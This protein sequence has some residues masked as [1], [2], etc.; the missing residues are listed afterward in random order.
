[1]NILII[2]G[3]SDFL[4]CK[5]KFGDTHAYGLAGNYQEAKAGMDS[6]ELVFDFTIEKDHSRL[7][8]YSKNPTC[9]FFLNTAKT[10]LKTLT[11]KNDALQRTFGFAG[12]P[13]FLNRHVL[14]VSLLQEDQRE[15]LAKVCR[16]LN[17]S[18]QV[19][20]DRV[21]LVTPR[22]ICMII[23]E[24]YYTVEE[25]TATREDI[26]TAMKLGTNYPFG[27]FEWCR[28]IGIHH[29][30]ELLEAVHKDSKD[31]R[32]KISQLLTDEHLRD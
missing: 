5:L 27:P 31:D 7:N 11:E 20:E 28:K 32:Y 29:V 1:M 12:L 24:A 3:A 23:N 19:V 26:D 15:Q 25:G 22:V 4:E 16:E 8:L 10:S 14:E 13:T 2:G 17:T 18:F 6:K 9:T 21:G 30:Y